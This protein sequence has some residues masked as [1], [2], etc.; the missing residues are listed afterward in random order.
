MRQRWS[1]PP[2]LNS[3]ELPFVDSTSH[4]G[5]FVERRRFANSCTCTM[6][7]HMGVHY[8]Q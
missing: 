1:L 5:T 2:P 7:V 8:E 6:H 4:R 3:A